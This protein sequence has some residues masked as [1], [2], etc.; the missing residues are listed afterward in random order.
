MIIAYASAGLIASHGIAP[1]AYAHAPV[2]AVKA[3][4]TSYQNSNSISVHPVPVAVHA[5]P[6]V[7]VHAVHAAPI[8]VHTVHAAPAYAVGHG[9]GLGHGYLH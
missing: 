3:G 5:A 4:A 2:V 6:A 8:A 7:A 1:V 9:L